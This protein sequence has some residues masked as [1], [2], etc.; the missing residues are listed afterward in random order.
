MCGLCRVQFMSN[1]YRATYT[2]CGV[3]L[4]KMCL[5]PVH[6]LT[7]YNLPDTLAKER[8]LCLYVCVSSNDLT[9]DEECLHMFQHSFQPHKSL[10]LVF[11]S[12]SFSFSPPLSP[13]SPTWNSLCFLCQ[14]G[15]LCSVSLSYRIRAET[16]R[17]EG[18]KERE[19]RRERDGKRDNI[20]RR[21]Q[22]GEQ[23]QDFFPFSW[24]CV[25][26]L[27]LAISLF[28]RRVC[29][30]IFACTSWCYPD[31]QLQWAVK[32]R[33]VVITLLL[34]AHVCACSMSWFMGMCMCVASCLRLNT[35]FSSR[36]REIIWTCFAYIWA[37]MCTLR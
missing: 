21:K 10:Q 33:V 3:R 27:F 28:R 22:E 1:C 17:T 14:Q 5:S 19:N 18:T 6:Q 31:V 8:D 24:Q 12:Q 16:T 7:T 29:V 35:L 11:N 34:T 20:G 25:H 37:H 26:P 32:C 9:K 2:G 4:H 36:W 15:D 30:S 13:L 23:Q